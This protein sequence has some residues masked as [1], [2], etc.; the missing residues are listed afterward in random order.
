MTAVP[1]VLIIEPDEVLRVLLFTVVR[2][3]QIAIDTASSVEDAFTKVTSCDYALIVLDL[4]YADG[5]ADRFLEQ[6]HLARP[7]AT[8]FVIGIHSGTLDVRPRRV[9][10]LM[11]K[12]LELDSVAEAIRECA[13]VVPPPV[14]PINCPP[15]E[16][17]PPRA[18]RPYPA[19]T[20]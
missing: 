7:T 3:H 16:S 4:D 19:Y 6:F 14:D 18:P 10:A 2:N 5:A 17:E 15:A 9:H 8:S 11:R 20:Q 1:R 12:P 13:L